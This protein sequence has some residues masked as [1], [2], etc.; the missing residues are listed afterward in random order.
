[1]LGYTI[2]ILTHK[3]VTKHLNFNCFC[4]GKGMSICFVVEMKSFA[5]LCFFLLLTSIG[6][7]FINVFK[8]K[9]VGLHL[10]CIHMVSHLKSH[11]PH[12]RILRYFVRGKGK[13]YND[14]MWQKKWAFVAWML[15]A[16]VSVSSFLKVGN[17]WKF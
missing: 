11:I 15:H 16:H 3:N 12:I 10:L 7:A 6:H 17:N 14:Y 2:T 8:Q 13:T 1:M 4:Q 5:V 9:Y